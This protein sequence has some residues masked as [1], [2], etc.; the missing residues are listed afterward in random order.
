MKTIQRASLLSLSI[1][2]KKDQKNDVPLSLSAYKRFTK[3]LVCGLI[4]FEIIRLD[5]GF[6]NS[7][8]DSF[9]PAFYRFIIL[10]SD[11]V[12]QTFSL[13]SVLHTLFAIL[14]FFRDD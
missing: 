3:Y 10:S 14:E 1:A 2:K 4:C 6:L 7:L 12:F 8:L 13:E 5:S 11:F 9:S